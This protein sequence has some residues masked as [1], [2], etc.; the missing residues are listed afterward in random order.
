[1]CVTLKSRKIK[2]EV[3]IGSLVTFAQIPIN[4]VTGDDD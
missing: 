1:M 2:Y 3:Y 4:V